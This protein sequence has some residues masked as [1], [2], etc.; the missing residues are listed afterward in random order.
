MLARAGTIAAFR[1]IFLLAVSG[2]G[3]R[4]PNGGGRAA[5]IVGLRRIR[6]PLAEGQCGGRQHD[7]TQLGHDRIILPKSDARSLMRGVFHRA[8][9]R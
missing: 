3:L 2:S 9:L 8:T 7:E 6:G 5:R 4:H 1:A